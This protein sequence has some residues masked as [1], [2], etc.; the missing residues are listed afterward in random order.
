MLDQV[1]KNVHL[2]YKIAKD[3]LFTQMATISR[4]G[5]MVILENMWHKWAS[6]DSLTKAAKRVG[7]TPEGLSVNFMQQD[8]FEQAAG[9]MDIDEEPSTSTSSLLTPNQTVSSPDH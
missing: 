5:F 1:N 3:Q 4:E 8:K 6:V 9:C 2:E 7:I